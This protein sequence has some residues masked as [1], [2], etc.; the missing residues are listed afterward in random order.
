MGSP[1]EDH[2]P[3]SWVV[4]AP[5]RPQYKLHGCDLVR[6]QA[7]AAVGG[8][9]ARAQQRTDIPAAFAGIGDHP[10]ARGRAG[11]GGRPERTGSG[12]RGLFWQNPQIGRLAPPWGAATAKFS[13]SSAPIAVRL[14]EP[15]IPPPPICSN[16]PFQPP[17]GIHTSQLTLELGPGLVT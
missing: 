17:A 9:A 3:S 1:R 13:V 12:G 15:S 16:R 14:I 7:G 2:F 10:G 6:A 4:G 11:R 8:V 5:I